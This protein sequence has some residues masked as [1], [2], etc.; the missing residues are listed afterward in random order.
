[1]ILGKRTIAIIIAG[2]TLI[3]GTFAG[4]KYMN[5]KNEREALAIK[6]A[7]EERI[8]EEQ[9]K[10]EERIARIQ[11]NNVAYLTFDDGPHPERTNKILDILKA[12]DV[13]ATFFVLGEQA[14]K[15]PEIIK[16]IYDEGH[17]IANHSTNHKYTYPTKE[18]YL[19]DIRNTDSIISKAIG[20]EYKSLYVRVPGGS[21]GKSLVKEAIAEDGRI[22]LNWTALTGDSEKNIMKSKELTFERFKE[23]FGDDKYEVVLMHDIKEVTVEN[24]QQL[25]DYIK[26]N[27][28][29][30]EPLVA[31][32]PVI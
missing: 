19:E 18:A 3:G 4:Y 23:T 24:L 10:E 2:V 22:D 31:D 9:R 20:K 6:L 29:I 21:M 14:E 13:K 15:Y 17:T 16:R 8:Q 11:N 28:Y 25:I 12:N 1:M 5:I 27:N 7:E 32:S 26:A 30:L